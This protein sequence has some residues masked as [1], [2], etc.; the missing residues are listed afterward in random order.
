MLNR[1]YIFSV[2]VALTISTFSFAQ[3]EVKEVELRPQNTYR[4]M[5]YNVENL[6]D[7]YD[8]STKRDGEFTPDGS[9]HWDQRKFYKK[10]D[11]IYTVI[12]AVGGWSHP[13]YVGLSEVEN[14][15]VLEQLLKTT[16]LSQYPYRIIHFES[17]DRR[18]IDVAALYDSTKME[19]LN[20]QAIPIVFPY[21]T[22]R[23]TRDI[24]LS[25]FKLKEDQVLHVF[26]C[27]W[28]SKYGG[29]LKTNPARA[30]VGTVVKKYCDSLMAVDKTA[31]IIVTGDLNDTPVDASVA[32]H[33]GAVY[34]EGKKGSLY[35]ISHEMTEAHGTHKY[36]S[37]WSV[38][39]HF[40]VSESL[41]RGTDGMY[42]V[43]EKAHIF[44][45]DFLI[46]KDDRY[47]GIKPFRTYL[48]MRFNGGYSDHLPIY[49]DVE[50]SE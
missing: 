16:P 29:V 19:L 41:F 42:L 13:E 22:S 8:D 44:T 14:R 11:D 2:F 32:E 6:F 48:G 4:I 50:V 3:G 5:S 35:N 47:P 34:E 33:L 25:T 27:H 37:E 21:D 38:I 12:S 45:A 7:T 9:K 49:V 43:T 40:I 18:G 24:L 10:L 17:P 26:Q 28:P 46:E 20:A 39:D 23:K 31:K 30:Y 15:Y 1:Q 36:R